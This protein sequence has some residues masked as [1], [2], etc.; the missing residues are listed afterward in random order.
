MWGKITMKKLCEILA[1]ILLTP[2]T[3]VV[4]LVGGA[5]IG[6]VFTIYLPF[7]GV[8]RLWGKNDDEKE[9]QEDC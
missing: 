8:I 3:F 5:L 6:A 1:Y 7:A 2:F 9:I 4:C